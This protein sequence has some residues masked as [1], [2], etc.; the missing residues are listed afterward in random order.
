VA[1]VSNYGG[2]TVTAI[3]GQ[4]VQAVP[5][6]VTIAALPGNQTANSSPGFTFSARSSFGPNA[7]SPQNVFF[8]VDTW[9]GPWTL[10]STGPSSFGGTVP[11][12]LPGFHILYAF[13]DD[14]QDATSV[15]PDSP[16][17]GAIAA[18]GFLVASGTATASPYFSLQPSSQTTAS[19]DTVAFNAL[20]QRLGGGPLTYQWFLDTTAIPGATDSTYVIR[21]ATSAD[22]G[23]Y[24]C[25]ATNPASAVASNPATL[26]VV[27]SVNPGRL[28][29]ISC[30]VQV[31]TGP[32]Q[33]I[34][35]FVVGGRNA[36]GAEPLLIRA[37][38]PA[39]SQFD[40]GVGGC[41]RVA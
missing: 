28:I 7:P 36:S 31:G 30:R 6:S 11:P 8:E 13:A 1:F 10:A 39:L 38:G 20:A 12:L 21:N 23:T 34:A 37:S 32:Q 29:D 25:V 40:L 24:T 17:V 35:G 5:L 16:L 33:L 2:G 18:Y 26:E 41:V 4:R 27:N 15:Q 9:Q 14:S 19:G 3:V 22:D